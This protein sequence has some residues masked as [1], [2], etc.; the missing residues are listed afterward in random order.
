MHL[1]NDKP[2]DVSHLSTSYRA[3]RAEFPL[4][5]YV[6]SGQSV[7]VELDLSWFC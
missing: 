3:V 6:I 1:Y 5:I 7:C 2:V 4:I